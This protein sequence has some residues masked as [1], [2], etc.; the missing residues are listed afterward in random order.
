MTKW[1]KAVPV[2]CFLLALLLV[3]GECLAGQPSRSKK[4][5][6]SQVDRLHRAGNPHTVAW[7]ARASVTNHYKPYYVGGGAAIGGHHR[8]PDEGTWGL[9]YVGGLLKRHVRLG[10]W[11]GRR[12]QDGGGTYKTDGPHLKRH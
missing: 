7:Y 10:W 1:N 8:A 12:E 5:P 11:H 9:D 4:Q 3:Q 2:Y 6:A